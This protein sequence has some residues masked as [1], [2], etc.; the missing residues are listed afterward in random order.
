MPCSDSSSALFD[1]RNANRVVARFKA[2]GAVLLSPPIPGHAGRLVHGEY[3]GHEQYQQ[4]AR[5][6]NDKLHPRRRL[7]TEGIAQSYF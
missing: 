2:G 4:A 3:H 7:A 5:G 6:V 1:G